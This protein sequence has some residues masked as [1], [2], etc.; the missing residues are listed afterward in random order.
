MP[1]TPSPPLLVITIAPVV[2]LVLAVPTADIN[3]A[4][5]VAVLFKVDWPVT[6]K[7]PPV[8]ILPATAAPP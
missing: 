8:L 5:N 3:A 4:L 2:V 7:L 1:A 6:V